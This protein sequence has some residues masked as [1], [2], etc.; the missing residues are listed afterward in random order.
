[1][2]ASAVEVDETAV[3][4]SGV[5]VLAVVLFHRKPNRDTVIAYEAAAIEAYPIEVDRVATVIAAVG[6]R[7]K[8]RGAD[9]GAR[10]DVVFA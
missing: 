5:L 8:Q 10:L 3:D 2:V 6:L 9:G 4:V 7:R 1:M